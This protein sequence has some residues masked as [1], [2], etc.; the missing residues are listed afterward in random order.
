MAELEVTYDQ[1]ADAAYI[2]LTDPRMHPQSART[3]PCDPIGVDGMINLD[4]D[5]AG[6]LIGIEVL[7]ARSKLPQSLLNAATRIDR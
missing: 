7:D 3:Y 4:F 6:R 1:A 2:Y 5:D